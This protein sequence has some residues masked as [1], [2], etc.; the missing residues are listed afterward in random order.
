M[1]RYGSASQTAASGMTGRPIR[2][3]RSATHADVAPGPGRRRRA[4]RLI[5]AAAPA[6]KKISGMTCA[7]QV[8]AQPAPVAS[9]FAVERTPSSYDT[10]GISQCKHTIVMI[11]VAR[12]RSMNRSRDGREWFAVGSTG[13]LGA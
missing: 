6:A 2:W 5:A 13:R 9:A 11:A 7:T 4:S 8:I 3:R 12:S 10:T 1:S